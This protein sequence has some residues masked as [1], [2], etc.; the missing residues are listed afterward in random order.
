MF[1][2]FKLIFALE[3]ILADMEDSQISALPPEL[4]AEAQNLRREW[5]SR[6]RHMQDRFFT[7][8]GPST[9]SQILRSHQAASGSREYLIKHILFHFVIYWYINLFPFFTRLFCF[10]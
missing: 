6:N 1:G 8:Q 2:I 7:H 4:A 3:Q 10:T 9:L 5:E